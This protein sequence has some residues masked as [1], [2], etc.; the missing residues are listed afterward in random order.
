M[1]PGFLRQLLEEALAVRGVH[2]IEDCAHFGG[3]PR[4]KQNVGEIVGKIADE[5]GRKV[6][7]Q[8]REKAALAAE[9]QLADGVGGRGGA[10]GAKFVDRLIPLALRDQLLEL[11]VDRRLHGRATGYYDFRKRRIT[12]V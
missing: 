7:R 9:R 11:S 6:N 2:L 5:R 8:A 4:V 10:E 12:L 1:A 3:R